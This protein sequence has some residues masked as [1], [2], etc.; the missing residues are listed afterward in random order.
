VA[1]TLTVALS[2][3]VATATAGGNGAT[4]LRAELP[5]N[6]TFDVKGTS[7]FFTF[8]CDEQRVQRPDG[9]A[10]ETS[11]C[12]LDPGQ[13]PP[14][15]AAQMT[16][17]LYL[18]DFFIAGTPGFAGASITPDYHGVLTPSGRVTMVAEFAAP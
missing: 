4:V 1:V 18:S 10:R 12:E 7:T 2:V 3:G 14:K 8:T 16:P 9:S 13:T 15:S 11:H 5:S 17:G 6:F